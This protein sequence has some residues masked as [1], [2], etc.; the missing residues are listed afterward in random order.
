M[1]REFIRT[2]QYTTAI[3]YGKEDIMENN[4]TLATQATPPNDTSKAHNPPFRT[5]VIDV[6]GGFRA[7]FGA[8]VFDYCLEHSISF[9]HCYGVSAGSANLGSFLSGQLGRNHRFYTEYSFRKEYASTKN[10]VTSRNFVNLEY[11]YSTLS[12]HDGEY[13][14]DYEAF[15]KNPSKFTVVACNAL[16]GNAF[17]FEKSD[18]TFDSFE[19][20]KASSCVPLACEPYYV[21]GIPFFDG[22][23][24]DPIPV[25]RALD[26]GAERIVIILSRPVELARTSQKDQLPARLLHHHY[27]QVAQRVAD[28]HKTYNAQIE[29]SLELQREGKALILAPHEFYGLSTLHKS[30]E[31]LEQMYRKGYEEASKINDFLQIKTAE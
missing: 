28:R 25:Q 1:E 3:N 14:V 30:Y 24:V 22:G 20:L 11:V 18:I 19:P 29:Q 15:K 17:Y 10:L 5:A 2:H 9:D 31:G 13:P 27:P 12:N 7:I 23:I 4:E 21:H 26:D 8:G 16:D 6:G